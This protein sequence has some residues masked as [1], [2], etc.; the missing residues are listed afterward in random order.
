MEHLDALRLSTK[1]DK[2]DVTRKAG[3]FGW[4]YWDFILVIEKWVWYV[5]KVQ[6]NGR[7]VKLKE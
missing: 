2:L 1:V 6:I 5:Q 3:W 7:D 4:N